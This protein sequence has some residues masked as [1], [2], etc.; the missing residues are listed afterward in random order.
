M[1][2]NIDILLPTE[3]IVGVLKPRS[4]QADAVFLKGFGTMIEDLNPTKVSQSGPLLMLVQVQEIPVLSPTAK[5]DQH[6]SIQ[7]K[8]KDNTGEAIL[9]LWGNQV[10]LTRILHVG[11]YVAVYNVFID[12]TYFV[13]GQILLEITVES[14]ILLVDDEITTV[15]PKATDRAPN[16]NSISGD[17]HG[18]I[19]AKVVQI[20]SEIT[21]DSVGRMTIQLQGQT[22]KFKVQIPTLDPKFEIDAIV[23]EDWLFIS[24]LTNIRIENMQLIGI[25]SKDTTIFN[26]FSHLTSFETKWYYFVLVS[27]TSNPIKINFKPFWAKLLRCKDKIQQNGKAGYDSPRLW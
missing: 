22:G 25:A 1:V 26:S 20:G 18:P 8:V 3:T 11:S 7:I 23:N 5:F 15:I 27:C 16:I 14:V 21:A 24:N 6:S 17:F 12:P 9:C 4:N 10:A 13:P 19:C 2:P